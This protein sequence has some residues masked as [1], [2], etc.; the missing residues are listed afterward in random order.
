MT[1]DDAL[2][3]SPPPERRR[4]FISYKR[5]VEPDRTQAA[6]LYES[7]E[8]QGCAVFM[9]IEMTPGSE[10]EKQLSHEI[11]SS[12]FFVVLLTRASTATNGYVVAETMVARDSD[13]ATGHPKILPVRLAYTENL[14][15]RLRAAI[16]HLQHFEWR[17]AAD[18]DVLVAALLDVIGKPGDSDNQP[19]S[20]VRGDHYVI[21][22]RMWQS[23]GA[24]ES[25]AGT[26]I[27]PL[28]IGQETSLAVT[29]ARGPGFFGVRVQED[30]ALEV[31]IWKKAA[32]RMVESRPEQFVT[33]LEG[34]YNTW[35]FARR[36]P[37][38]ALLLKRPDGRKDPI[39]V[40]FDRD[41]VSA[42]WLVTHE[43]GTQ[44]E[45]FLIVAKHSSAE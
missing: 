27:V 45:S 3:G 30:G 28:R 1:P 12:D 9:D 11:A 40:T 15:L 18:N 37:D 10:W 35:C 4:V 39:V 43:R 41:L 23:A 14:P 32:Y 7:L 19:T 31:A 24:R 26:R 8:R 36:S 16:D 5:G 38:E 25:L 44:R 2:D 29:R 42:V 6:F 34:D 17:S 33:M 13:E 21:T 20:L 22:A